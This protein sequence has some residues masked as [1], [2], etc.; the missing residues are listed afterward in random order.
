LG[1]GIA[2]GGTIPVDILASPF[3][4]GFMSCK[5]F[6][7]DQVNYRPARIVCGNFQ[8]TISSSQQLWFALKVF[9]PSM[10]AGYTK[11]SIP[12]FLYSVEQGTTYKT[13]FDVI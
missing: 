12:F 7:G 3:A 9:N 5:L 2:D 6:I 1:T 13:N 4:T 8:S 11:L 10:P